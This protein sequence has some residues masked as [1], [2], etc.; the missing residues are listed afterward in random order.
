MSSS[1]ADFNA[2]EFLRE[3]ALSKAYQ[4]AIDLPE[5]TS[6]IPGRLTAKLDEQRARALPLEAAAESA[7][8]AYASAV[9]AWHQVED[10]LV[11]LV[12]EQDKLTQKHAEA[13]TKK[14]AAQKT[15][16]DAETQITIVRDRA[17]VLSD[18]AT[19]AQNAVKKIPKD[20]ELADAAAT[21]SRRHQTA[22]TELAALEKAAVEQKAALKKGIEDVVAAAKAV[23]G[24]R[25]KV[26]PARAAVRLKETVVAQT[27]QKMAETRE[28]AEVQQNRVKLLEAFVRYEDLRKDAAASKQALVARRDALTAAKKRPAEL[29][30]LLHERQSEV[31]AADLGRKSAEQAQADARIALDRHQ[32]IMTSVEQALRRRRPRSSFYLMIKRCRKPLRR[33]RRSQPRSGNA[34]TDLKAKVLAA[35]AAFAKA[36]ETHNRATAASTACQGEK[37]AREALVAAA[38]AAV[39]AAESRDKAAQFQSRRGGR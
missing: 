26:Q 30:A 16:T 3:L 33:S 6:A 12:A 13:T 25:A 4:Q 19:G 31:K 14:D 22:T 7:R 24:A 39:S 28:A 5:E 34:A 29:E 11:P 10:A 23:E 32:K 9:K 1:P 38:A 17:K 36:A 15:V 27:R 18:A 20:K 21:F 8:K 2:R 35:A 37:T